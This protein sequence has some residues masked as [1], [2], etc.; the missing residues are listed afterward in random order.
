MKADARA[1]TAALASAARASTVGARTP[2]GQARTV[3]RVEGLSKHF[4]IRRGMLQRVV[5]AVRAL[6]D[7]SFEVRSGEVFGLAGESGSGKSTLARIVVGLS[8]PSRG[9]VVVDGVDITRRG[10]PRASGKRVQMVFQNPGSSLNPRRSVAQTLD[11]PLVLSG[12]GPTARRS[13]VAELLEMVELPHAVA[14]KYPFE[15]SGGQKQRVAIARALALAPTLLVLDEPTSALDVSVQAKVIELLQRLRRELDLTYLFIS[16]DLSLMRAF[17]DRVGILYLAQLRE[18]GQAERVFGEPHHPYT[19]G[20]L[21]SVPVVTDEE[22]RLT[23]QFERI[24]GEIP[25]A[26]FVPRG[27][28]FHTRCPL[29]ESRCRRED[30]AASGDPAVHMVACH[31]RP[32]GRP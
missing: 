6:D 22:A 20:L 27:C 9:R 30:P 21:A 16:H 25:S 7:V 10:D 28:R 1:A 2:D 29:A 3:L 17:A 23:A 12:L 24:S 14:Q 8:R 5:G 26:A 11:L 4:P 15:L 31:V 19:R 13:R 18:I 32:I